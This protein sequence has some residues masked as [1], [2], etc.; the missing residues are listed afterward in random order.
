FIA[1]ALITGLAIEKCGD[2]FGLIISNDRTENFIRA[3]RGRKHYNICKNVLFDVKSRLTSPDYE[4]L[5]NFIGLNIRRRALLI[6]LT[7]L[8]EP[9]LAENFYKA[10]KSASPKH[11]VCVNIPDNKHLR[12]LFSDSG[13]ESLD[14]IYAKLGNHIIWKDIREI[15]KKL[16]R[17]GIMF[18]TA[19]IN[20]FGS[21]IA[22][23]YL[24]IKKRQLI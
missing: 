19:K 8:D 23:Q 11:L 17:N 4:E 6:I 20:S 7:N 3:G 9:V 21:D 1:S 18:K 5:F 2:L 10:S 24:E 16:A 14:D 15:E 12:P 13:V 22:S